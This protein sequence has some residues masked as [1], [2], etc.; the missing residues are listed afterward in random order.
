MKVTAET[1]E[2]VCR[3]HMNGYD[4]WRNT[5]GCEFVPDEAMRPIQFIEKF[6]VH[7][8]G[9]KAG[10][11]VELDLW[12][13]A[14]VGNLFGWIRP[15]G[16]RRYR[17]CLLYVPRKNGKSLIGASIGTFMF[18]CDGEPGFEIY[19]AA[20]DASQSR[21]VWN[22]AKQMIEKSPKLADLVE[23]YTN[24]IK[25]KGDDSFWKPVSKEPGTK[26]GFNTHLFIMDELHVQNGNALFDALNTSMVARVQPL[27]LYLTTADYSRPSV[28]N[29]EYE[30]AL[31]IR[32]GELN[33]P[34]YLPVIYEA[35]L[36]DDWTSEETWRKA[37]PGYGISVQPD[38]IREQC[39]RAKQ[40]PTYENTFKR[41][42]LNIRTEQS[43]RMIKMDAWDKCNRPLEVAALAGKRCFA[44]LD[45]STT[46]DVTA[47]V[48]YFPDFGN[49]LL[50]RFWIPA[51]N[52]KERQ[53]RDRVEYL[54]WQ[55]QNLI[56][57]TPGN[58]IDYDYIRKELNE[59]AKTYRIMKIGYDPYNATELA[60]HLSEQDGLPMEQFR[61]GFISMNEP[62]KKFE[63]LIVSGQLNHGGNAVLRWMATN[64][65]AKYDAAGN[66]K[67]DK[68]KSAEK[69]DGMV[70]AAMAIGVSMQNVKKESVYKKRGVLVI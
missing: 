61:Q 2:Q 28:C 69:I 54:T 19:C 15:D 29:S 56:T 16:T 31:R 22:V 21:L 44:G 25:L 34:Y 9:G 43:E 39:E 59:L 63:A 32:N 13:C 64:V 14:F 40:M 12:Q 41:F 20:A 38:R 7:V 23:L 60:V 18:F 52:A 66:V 33:D 27:A 3:E 4:A 58:V 49:Y 26:M 70:A 45:L 8:K 10:H 36:T 48:L 55:R 5:A 37:N 46:R 51:E 42:Y 47:L 24:S 57:L 1:I 67:F 68:Q 62:I 17:T 53:E 65:S 35:K 50:C 30:L 11:P 6:C